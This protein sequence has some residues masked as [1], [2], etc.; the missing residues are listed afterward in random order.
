[1]QGPGGS[2][3]AGGAWG[4]PHVLSVLQGRGTGGENPRLASWL[5]VL[6]DQAWGTLNRPGS[7]V[8]GG[9]R[10]QASTHGRSLEP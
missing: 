5:A 10:S 1:M 8:C 6:I 2:G 7:W 9:V 3:Q 4:F